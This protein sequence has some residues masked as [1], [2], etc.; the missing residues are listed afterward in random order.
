MGFIDH[1]TTLTDLS[2]FE[3]DEFD[4]FIA[5]H[6]IEEI[7]DYERAIDEVAR[8]LGPG[9]KALLEIPFDPDREASER[10]PP[11]HFGNVWTFGRDLLDQLERRF[12]TVEALRLSEGAYRGTLLVCTAASDDAAAEDA[13]G[14]SGRRR[15]RAVAV[16]CRERSRR[17]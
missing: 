14:P 5:Q 6:V 8:V 11:D 2:M 13:P 17:R 3:D 1:E 7:E 9:A 4:L 10:Q 16:R 12:E 15:S